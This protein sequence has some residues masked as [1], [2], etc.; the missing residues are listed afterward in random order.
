M[1]AVLRECLFCC[2]SSLV[3]AFDEIGPLTCP[4][5]QGTSASCQGYGGCTIK[6]LYGPRVTESHFL[7]SRISC[8]FLL[9][10]N[11]QLQ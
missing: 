2:S 5:T 10:F 3:I 9:G 7:R 1:P 11:L 8:Y 6:W 4:F